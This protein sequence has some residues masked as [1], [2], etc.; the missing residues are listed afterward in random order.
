[1]RFSEISLKDKLNCAN[2][3]QSIH[4]IP[5]YNGVFS[6]QFKI[7]KISPILKSNTRND[8]EKYRPIAILIT[9]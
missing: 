1:M 9:K 8:K 2:Q 3:S 6:N 4:S 5:S 7:D